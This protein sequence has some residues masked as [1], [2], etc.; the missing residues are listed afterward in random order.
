MFG[1]T[2]WN[3]RAPRII[4]HRIIWQSL[5]TT[6]F[7]AQKGPSC[8]KNDRLIWQSVCMTFPPIPKG[9]IISGEPCISFFWSGTVSVYILFSWTLSTLIASGRLSM[10]ARAV[11]GVRVPPPS[12]ICTFR[13]VRRNI[14]L[15]NLFP[16]DKS[17]FAKW[18]LPWKGSKGNLM[19]FQ[20]LNTHTSKYTLCFSVSTSC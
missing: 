6:I 16:Q 7:G 15:Q 2:R 11:G 3:Y 13:I 4:W 14:K 10:K 20:V 12:S 8:T 17:S 18:H 19:R 9:V 1:P 5:Y